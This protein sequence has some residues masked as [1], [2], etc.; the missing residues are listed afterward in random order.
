V[1]TTTVIEDEQAVAKLIRRPL[2]RRRAIGPRRPTCRDAGSSSVVQNGPRR[3][4]G[5]VAHDESGTVAI[6]AGKFELYKDAAGGFRFRLKAANGEIIAT[7][8][9]Y[10]SKPGAQNGIASVKTNADSPIV[11]LT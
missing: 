5:A 6:M 1:T 10:A 3:K 7:S 11:D 8:E 2:K 4:D 9:S